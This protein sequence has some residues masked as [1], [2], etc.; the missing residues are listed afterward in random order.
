MLHEL[1]RM[2]LYKALVVSFRRPLGHLLKHIYANNKEINTV[3]LTALLFGGIGAEMI[4][5]MM[6]LSCFKND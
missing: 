5:S 1:T 2:L 6:K 4:C 3:L